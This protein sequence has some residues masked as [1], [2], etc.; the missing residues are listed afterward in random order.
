M[1]AVVLYPYQPSLPV[2]E[3]EQLHS[4]LLALG[5][6]AWGDPP[7]DGWPDTSCKSGPLSPAKTARPMQMQLAQFSPLSVACNS[8]A[9]KAASPLRG[10]TNRRP[11]R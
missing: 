7:L 10:Y 9:R 5:L 3:S 8:R 6:F 11:L 4:V 1:T 2:W